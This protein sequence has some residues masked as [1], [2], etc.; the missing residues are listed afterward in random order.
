MT[1]SEQLQKSLNLSEIIQTKE[2]QALTL[3]EQ[4]IVVACVGRKIKEILPVDFQTMMLGLI[5]KAHLNTN[6]KME[7]DQIRLTISDF[8][9]DVQ[10]LEHALTFTE[11]EFAF[12]NGWKKNYGEFMGL[13]NATYW[14]WINMY[15]LSKE[16]FNAKKMITDAM[17]APVE[18]P[19][20]S[21][22]QKE[23][24]I[25][26]GV[27]DEFENY[28]KTKQ[29]ED[30]KNV[31]YNYLDAKKIINNTR[32]QKKE[33]FEYCRQRM[34]NEYKQKS[35]STKEIANRSDNIQMVKSL[36]EGNPPELIIASKK[37]A[38]KRYFDSLIEF[39]KELVDEIISKTK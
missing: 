16:R 32:D 18:K 39:E 4:E 11:I 36:L 30:P 17:F 28:K 14:N 5:G 35:I 10:R 15:K 6:F 3:N 8:C 24:I 1:P 21:E 9:G 19:Q 33:I 26:D 29:L 23:K 7:S 22:E 2:Y 31:F 20:L 38:L 34:I 12:K 25:I 13:S 27:L 37:E